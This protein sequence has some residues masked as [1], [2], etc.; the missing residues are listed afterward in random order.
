MSLY[1]YTLLDAC[2]IIKHALAVFHLQIPQTLLKQLAGEMHSIYKI[3]AGKP[4]YS[5]C[6][7]KHKAKWRR[8]VGHAIKPL[9][10]LGMP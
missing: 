3:G 7:S 10:H 4:V 9:A 6:S 2:T 1:S 8:R 5:H